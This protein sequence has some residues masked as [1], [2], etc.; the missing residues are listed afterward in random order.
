MALLTSRERAFLEAV[1]RI[2][3][4]NPFLPELLEFERLALGDA[5]VEEEAMWSLQVADPERI[6]GNTGK[7]LPRLQALLDVLC[8]RLKQDPTASRQELELYEDGLLYWLY[9]R[10]HDWI[11][12]VGLDACAAAS[13]GRPVGFLHALSE[14]VGALSQD[15]G[16]GDADRARAPPHVRLLLPNRP[17]VP[18]HVREHHR[19]LGARRAFA[20]RRLA[21]GVHPRH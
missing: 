10:Y 14:G 7:I 4:C 16:R 12:G 2:S 11:F 5:F 17:G 15:S 20:G 3:Y 21:V 8:E 13:G 18:Q 9:Y 6:R 19:E 1:A